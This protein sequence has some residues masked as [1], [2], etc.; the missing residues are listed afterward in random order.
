MGHDKVATGAEGFDERTAPLYAGEARENL[1]LDAGLGKPASDDLSTM[2]SKFGLKVRETAGQDEFY[3]RAGGQDNVVLK[4]PAHEATTHLAEREITDTL[5]DRVHEI[6]N[7]YKVR[8]AS[9]GEPV[10]KQTVK[11]ADCST[12]PGEMIYA[13]QPTFSGLFAVKEA[14]SRSQPSQ[15][16]ADG[17][18]GIKIYFL[19]K[20]ILPQPVYGNKYALGLY[21]P[22][23]KDGRISMYIT[24]DGAKAAPTAKDVASSPDR[25]LQ[26]ILTHEATHNSQ[27]NSWP[28][29][30]PYLP[31]GLPEQLG[32]KTINTIEKEGKV[33]FEAYLLNGKN[34]ESYVNVPASCAEETKWI[35]VKDGKVVG[36][37]GKPTDNK[38]K[39]RRFTN[40][41]V[42]ERAAVKPISY[43]FPNPKEMLSEALSAYRGGQDMRRYLYRES[44]TLYTAAKNYDDQEISRVYG[45][46]STGQSRFL[47]TPDGLLAKRDLSSVMNLR[48][49]EESL[50]SGR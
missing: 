4:L 22:Q 36:E 26:W 27:A 33:V 11:K 45:L 41:E 5:Q 23:D 42:M 50:K 46:D 14:M 8:I 29:T 17:K 3:F 47:R 15:L 7:D 2:A 12:E 49:F 32:W 21:I 43:Y 24:P 44:P 28:T 19:D 35:S 20:Q 38:D 18:D 48:S 34:G 10:E 30:F 39:V 40:E 16:T 1:S 37:D 31:K 9:P 6:E 13:T 25:N